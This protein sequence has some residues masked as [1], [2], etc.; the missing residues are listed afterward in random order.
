MKNNFG[1]ISGLDKA[2]ERISVLED[3]SVKTTKTKNKE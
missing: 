2:G 3:I 1:L